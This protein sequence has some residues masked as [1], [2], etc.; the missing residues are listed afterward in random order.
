MG[1]KAKEVGEGEGRGVKMEVNGL[2]KNSER[3]G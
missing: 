1:D 3:I 2:A